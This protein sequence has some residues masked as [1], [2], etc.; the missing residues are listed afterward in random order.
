MTADPFRPLDPE[1]RKQ[2]VALIAAECSLAATRLHQLP[3]GLSTPEKV[4]WVTSRLP[5]HDDR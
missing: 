3:R 5:E 2:A 4:D 1:H